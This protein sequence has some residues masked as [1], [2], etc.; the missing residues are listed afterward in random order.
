MS[1]KYA[2]DIKE[3]VRLGSAVS[4]K[5]KETEVEDK[6]Y[7]DLLC[8]K[9]DEKFKK[10]NSREIIEELVG[11]Y[12]TI[13]NKM[14]NTAFP[15]EGNVNP[16]IGEGAIIKNSCNA[17]SKINESLRNRA[18][19]VFQQN[20]ITK[21]A[22]T[23][24]QHMVDLFWHPKIPENTLIN[25]SDLEEKADW[26]ELIKKKKYTVGTLPRN[27][28]LNIL[29]DVVCN[30]IDLV[31]CCFPQIGDNKK[32]GQAVIHGFVNLVAKKG[33]VSNQTIGWDLDD[34]TAQQLE[35]NIDRKL[36]VMG[37]FQPNSNSSS[38]NEQ[39]A[40]SSGEHTP[41]EKKVGSSNVGAS[42]ALIAAALGKKIPFRDMEF[43]SDSENDTSFAL[44]PSSED[45]EVAK[46]RSPYPNRQLTAHKDDSDD[47]DQVQ[48]DDDKPRHTP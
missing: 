45:E 3:L 38:R 15:A 48:A 4:S 1:F 8:Q 6:S 7:V 21:L 16:L 41:E 46:D 2:H 28:D 27:N 22:K 42:V 39:S 30:H 12:L 43:Q 9:I 13:R 19:K 25:L 26:N 33:Q 14:P 36:Y 20:E 32:L 29:C 37:V 23:I 31:L 17:L 35:K 24:A 10:D 11:V 40:G 34:Q 44:Q 5:T 18:N 47:N